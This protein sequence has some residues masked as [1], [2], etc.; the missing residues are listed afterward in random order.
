MR[1]IVVHETGGPEAL[2]LEDVPVPEPGPGQVRVRVHY[3]GVNF[4]DVYHRTGLYALERPFTPGSEAAGEVDAVG[5]GVS[6]FRPGERVAYAMER[7]AYAEFALVPAW[8]LVHV[9][10]D[11]GLDTAAA[12][13]LQ[14]MTA[15]YL[16]HST[17]PLREGQSALVHAAAGGVGLLL[18]QVA[19]QL[20]ARVIGTASTEEKARLAREAGADDVV[21]YTNQDF[22][23]AARHFGGGH[24]VDVVYDS[25]GRTTF[26]GSLNALKR[27][28]MLVMFGQS[29]GSVP[30][31]DLG[32]LARRGS[33]FL[34]RPSLADYIA[35]RDELLGRARDVFAWISDGTL[36][37]RIHTAL[38][39][40]DAAEAHRLL[41]GRQTAGK[42]L[43]HVQGEE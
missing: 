32:V 6:E 25:V 35:G 24:G 27:R 20:G 21:I 7:G 11:V 19:K 29:S 16:T 17:Y 33:L 37:V 34:T 31:F 3:A 40:E 12:V 15:H 30:P 1:A 23:T 18:V 41:E 43:L 26:E 22:V 14:G 5:P 4:I 13:M 8:K 39:L 42:V 2:H 36:K 10:D 38:Q 9:P 28:G